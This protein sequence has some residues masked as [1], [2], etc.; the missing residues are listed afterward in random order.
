[1]GQDLPARDLQRAFVTLFRQPLNPTRDPCRQP[2]CELSCSHRAPALG[3]RTFEQVQS[4]AE[5]LRIIVT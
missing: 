5:T 2:T 3:N 1:M 4:H